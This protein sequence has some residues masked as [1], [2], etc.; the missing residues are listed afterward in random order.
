MC[1]HKFLSQVTWVLKAGNIQKSRKSTRFELK[2]VLKFPRIFMLEMAAAN[3]NKESS[4]LKSVYR[5]SYFSLLSENA[6]FI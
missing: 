6:E 5:L 4:Y 1:H 3:K 2:S